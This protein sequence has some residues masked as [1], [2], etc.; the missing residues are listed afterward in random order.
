MVCRFSTRASVAT[1]LS[2][3]PWVSSCL[4]TKSTCIASVWNMLRP[5]GICLNLPNSVASSQELKNYDGWN[6]NKIS[7]YLVCHYEIWWFLWKCVTASKSF[8]TVTA[9]EA[10][11]SNVFLCSEAP[12]ASPTNDNLIEFEIWPKFAVLWFKI[13]QPITTEFC[14]KSQSRSPES[15]GFTNEFYDN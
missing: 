6:C 4:W 10:L 3:H 8:V 2:T 12:G 13:T 11:K 15:F 7:W 14:T 5:Q 1:W 9:R